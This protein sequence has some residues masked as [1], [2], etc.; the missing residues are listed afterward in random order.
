MLDRHNGRRQQN[1]K[2]NLREL[3]FLL[4]FLFLHRSIEERVIRVAI[5]HEHFHSIIT[6]I[7]KH[8]KRPLKQPMAFQRPTNER[9]LLHLASRNIRSGALLFSRIRKV[10]SLSRSSDWWKAADCCF[11]RLLLFTT[12]WRR[13]L[14]QLT[15]CVTLVDQ[16]HTSMWTAEGA[17]GRIRV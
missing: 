6:Q 3:I 10:R 2:N 4:F 1:N 15:P 12:R 7:R 11:G 17:I 9:G 5:S 13:F 16:S 14:T 8:C